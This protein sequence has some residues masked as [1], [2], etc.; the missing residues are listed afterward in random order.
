MYIHR[1]TFISVTRIECMWRWVKVQVSL[2]CVRT[3][4][5]KFLLQQF[6]GHPTVTGNASDFPSLTL[7]SPNSVLYVGFHIPKGV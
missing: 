4:L 2:P 6:H 1:C 7:G 3:G 5:M